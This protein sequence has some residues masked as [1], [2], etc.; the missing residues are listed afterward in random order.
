[1]I[2]KE[3]ITHKKI[4]FD[5][6]PPKTIWKEISNDILSPFKPKNFTLIKE[7]LNQR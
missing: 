6:F 1:M 2:D 5:S 3:I 7:I 4:P